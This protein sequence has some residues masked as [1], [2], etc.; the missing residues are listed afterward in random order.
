VRERQGAVRLDLQPECVV[1]QSVPPP[2]LITFDCPGVHRK[3]SRN[4][5]E[6]DHG[7]KGEES[8]KGKEGKES[9]Q[10]QTGCEEDGSQESGEENREEDGQEDCAKARHRAEGRKGP[11]AAGQDDPHHRQGQGPGKETGS[12]EGAGGCG[13]SCVEAGRAAC[14]EA[15]YACPEAAHGRAT[16][17]T[18][19]SSPEAGHARS[20]GRGCTETRYAAGTAQAGCGPAQ[21]GCGPATARYAETGC[22]VANA[23][24]P[25]VRAGRPSF[26]CAAQTGLASA[27]GAVAEQ[28]RAAL[29]AWAWIRWHKR[30]VV[31]QSASSRCGGRSILPDPL[32][33]APCGCRRGAMPSSM[34][35][36]QAIAGRARV[37][38]GERNRLMDGDF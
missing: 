33:L 26:P 8:E 29:W 16:E 9:S 12:R 23:P 2:Q 30:F 10:G 19:P 7:E 20:T 6:D 37:R 25:D 36:L 11:G 4:D 34:R 28:P 5:R 27:V 38:T 21:A 1:E 3:V 31:A 18:G 15:A 22:A 32:L 17:A 35:R 14:P 24:Q 13:R